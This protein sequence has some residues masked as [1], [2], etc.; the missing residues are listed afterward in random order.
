MNFSPKQYRKLVVGLSDTV[1][2]KMCSKSWENIDFS[3]VPSVA[4]A[5]YQKAFGRNAPTQYGAY[6]EALQKIGTSDAVEGVKINAST[7]FPHD[8]IRSF[9]NGNKAIAEQQWKAL[10]NFAGVQNVLPIADVSG[11]MDTC[12][13]GSVTAMDVSIGL[14]MYISEK[15]DSAF[16]NVIMTFSDSPK[17]FKMTGNSTYSNYETVRN[18]NW[19]M[20][21][22]IQAA[23]KKILEFGKENNV[24][25]E[26]MPKYI[27]IIS[28]MEFDACARG[29]NYDSIKIQ[30]ENSGYELPKIVFW[31]V[32]A[33]NVQFP[34][35][36]KDDRTCLISGYS[37]SIMK[38]VL[39]NS[40]DTF[41][42]EAVMNDTVMNDTIMNE[43]YDI[44]SE[45]MTKSI[46]LV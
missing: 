31:N 5:R 36:S 7:L 38:S 40:L 14:A 46:S 28:D 3:K 43:R 21:T 20:N 2:Q 41:T 35:T 25:T 29:T 6:L 16:K 13:S 9:N 19:A 26:D 10:P 30:Y 27:L 34:I 12:V 17:L 44:V 37:P 23:F 8:V 4:S 15:Q 22:N 24:A 11:S 39:N 1:E 18:A 42:P 33:R 32:N 45:A